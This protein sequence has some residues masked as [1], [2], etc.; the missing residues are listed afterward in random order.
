MRWKFLLL[1]IFLASMTIYFR[2]R[3]A[4]VSA[5]V[6]TLSKQEPFHSEEGFACT[7]HDSVW[8]SDLA[9]AD[10]AVQETSESIQSGPVNICGFLDNIDQDSDYHLV[11]VKETCTLYIFRNS[12]QIGR[13]SASVG[14]NPDLSDKISPRD[15]RTPEGTFPI[16]SR[17][18]SA[19]WKLN[20]MKCYGPWFLRL[21]T[22][23]WKGIGI[24]GTD[25]PAS[26]GR[27]S[28]MGCIKVA[29][30]VVC[31]LKNLPLSTPVTIV[32]RSED[33]EAAGLSLAFHDGSSEA[34]ADAEAQ[35]FSENEGG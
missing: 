24:H 34:S 35:I 7:E 1:F 12:I 25:D 31:K 14:S 2:R 4:S 5:S 20:G 27:P 11:V 6:S 21:D 18:K 23:E 17:E 29:N 22:P 10:A 32:R 8:S 13:V 28:S 15:M 3:S 30:E 16:V 19:H 26:L 9:I 33:I